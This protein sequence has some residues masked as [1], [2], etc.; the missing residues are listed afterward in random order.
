MRRTG[1]EIIGVGRVVR[2]H[3]LV[4]DTGQ[5]R[6]ADG[7]IGLE[8]AREKRGVRGGDGGSDPSSSRA[9]P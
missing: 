9:A 2:V 3:R 5:E 1:G 4:A 7:Q 8:L 6:K